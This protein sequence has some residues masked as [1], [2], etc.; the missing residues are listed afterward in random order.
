MNKKILITGASGYVGSRI[1]QDLKNKNHSVTGLYNT[2]RLFNEIVKIDI[3]NK[4][5]V[6]KIFDSENPNIVVHLAAN[7]H[8]R[9][10]E[11]EPEQAYLL[12]VE[13]QSILR[14]WQKKKT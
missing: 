4:E 11:E 5:E 3:T 13:A 6:K 14:K 12:N 1:Y 8:S 2:T 10:C 9:S 7:A